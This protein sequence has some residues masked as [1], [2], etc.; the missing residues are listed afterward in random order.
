MRTG[1]VVLDGTPAEVFAPER[2]GLLA[3]TGLE[4]PVAARIGALLDLGSTPTVESL[5]ATLTGRSG[6]EVPPSGPSA[7]PSGP[8]ARDA[9]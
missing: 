5:L 9:S 2:H 1:E 8:S 7:R 4:P 6:P 3:S